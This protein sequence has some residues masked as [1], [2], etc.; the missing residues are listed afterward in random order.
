MLFARKP[1]GFYG[2]INFLEYFANTKHSN[3]GFF[4]MQKDKQQ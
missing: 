4:Y 2:C 1:V 3:V